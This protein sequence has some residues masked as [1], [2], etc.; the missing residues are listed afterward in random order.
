[1]LSFSHVSVR[2]I[3]A[4]FLIS[5]ETLI[6]SRRRSTLLSRERTLDRKRD[7]IGGLSALALSLA[8]MP[9]RFPLFCLRSHRFL[10]A[11][12]KVAGYEYSEKAL[13]SMVKGFHVHLNSCR[14]W[15]G[16][17]VSNRIRK[18][19]LWLQ[20]IHVGFN[21]LIAKLNKKGAPYALILANRLYGD[22][23]YQFVE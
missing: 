13:T 8:S 1:M 21:K 20:D 11:L 23:T 2:Q 12:T 7:G 15:Y 17:G 14:K 19:L 3:T 9:A 18:E 10:F 4:Q 6:L 22:K 16:P 5:S